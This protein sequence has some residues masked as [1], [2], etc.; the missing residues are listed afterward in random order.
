MTLFKRLALAL[1]PDLCCVNSVP[2]LTSVQVL[3]SH[4][5]YKIG[6]DARDSRAFEKSRPD[7]S[8]VLNAEFGVVQEHGDPRT[9]GVVESSNAVCGEEQHTSVIL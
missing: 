4:L 5:T 6:S 8:F 7:L 3:S 1:C 2:N 9:E